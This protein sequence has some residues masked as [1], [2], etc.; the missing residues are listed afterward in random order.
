M[1][2]WV[3]SSRVS[4]SPAIASIA[5]HQVPAAGHVEQVEAHPL[6][7]SDEPRQVA[8]AGAAEQRDEGQT[9]RVT[10]AVD[11]RGTSV[12]YAPDALMSSTHAPRAHRRVTGSGG[13]GRQ[14]RVRRHPG[15]DLG[16][17]R[18][19]RSRRSADRSPA[20]STRTSRKK[21]IASVSGPAGWSVKRAGKVLRVVPG[22]R[23]VERD[24]VVDRR[25]EES[26]TDALP[27]RA[28]PAQVAEVRARAGARRWRAG[29]DRA[30]AGEGL[31]RSDPPAMTPPSRSRR[32][33]VP[34]RRRRQAPCRRGERETAAVP[35]SRAES[36]ARRRGRPHRRSDAARRAG[37][38]QAAWSPSL[39][40]SPS[41]APASA[42]P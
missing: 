6:V 27:A 35:T 41:R 38:R 22:D 42:A 21:K 24:D 31:C 25:D 7:P 8:G 3:I 30:Q 2:G 29:L 36:R 39:S 16:R 4:K 17:R 20:V 23:R 15:S 33:R 28:A 1:T 10:V 5:D 14:A 11:R 26:V 32:C 18:C 12:V 9:G 19:R 37:D 40:G 34:R 13:S